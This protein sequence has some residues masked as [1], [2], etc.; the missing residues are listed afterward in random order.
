MS[1]AT[2]SDD[3]AGSLGAVGRVL[4]ESEAGRLRLRAGMPIAPHA[5]ILATTP[6]ARLVLD[7]A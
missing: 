5:R 3:R 4:V 2:A 1:T 7:P 6:G